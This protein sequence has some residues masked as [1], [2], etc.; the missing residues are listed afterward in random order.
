MWSA[1]GGIHEL[2]LPTVAGR[3]W[4]CG[5]HH[6]APQLDVVRAATEFT[7][8][9]CLTQRSELADRFP[10][11]VAWLDANVGVDSEAAAVWFP[12]ADLS[13]PPLSTVRQFLD[14][15]VSRLRAG[16]RIVMH[17]AAGIGRTGTI[18]VCVL[19]ELGMDQHVAREHVRA[20]RPMAGPEVGAQDLLVA[21]LAAALAP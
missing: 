21:D 5:K 15:L 8:V 13:M 2:P 11:Y 3:L 17:C 18:A 10:A 6:I 1:D 20:H 16:Q 4:L 14:D 7:S 12:I 19:M 9:V